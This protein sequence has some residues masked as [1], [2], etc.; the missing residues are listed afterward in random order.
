M[1]SGNIAARNCSRKCCRLRTRYEFSVAAPCY[2]IRNERG[3]QATINLVRFKGLASTWR[4]EYGNNRRATAFPRQ[5]RF[6]S[7][8]Q[9]VTRAFCHSPSCSLR[10]NSENGLGGRI[11]NAI[12]FLRTYPPR[13]LVPVFFVLEQ[14]PIQVFQSVG[15]I[16]LS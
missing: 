6:R 15:K 1:L 13:S 2:S 16:K 5:L 10:S 14:Q 4:V 7:R 8:K 9:A 11:L 12:H 3:I